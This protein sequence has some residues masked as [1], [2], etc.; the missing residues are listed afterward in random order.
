MAAENAE[1]TG[2][3]APQQAR[4]RAALQRLLTA[5]E[6]VLINDGVD[7][8]TIARVAEH[9]GVSVG[10]VYRRFAGKDQ[11]IQAVRQDLL[12]R[13]ERAVDDALAGAAPSVAGVL[14]AF[15]GALGEILA[16]SG[17]VI[18]VI[19]A[20]SRVP[21]APEQAGQVLAGLQQ[22]F[23][24]TITPY[25]G[26]IAHPDPDRALRI[27]FR[28]VAGAAVHRTAIIRWWPDGLDWDGWARE[29]ADMTTAYLTSARNPT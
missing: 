9:A 15:T 29:I 17:Q 24:D 26:E 18:P 16:G 12:A 25:R 13:M 10:G 5:A 19:L 21:E 3:P 8:F 6:D 4:S 20:G 1:T 27:A 22:R 14:A 28:T 2:M 23:L 7:E 11:L